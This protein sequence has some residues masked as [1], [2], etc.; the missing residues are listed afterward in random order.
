MIAGAMF[1]VFSFQ[2]SVFSTGG[3][4]SILKSELSEI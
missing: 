3:G 4:R 1:L 2:F